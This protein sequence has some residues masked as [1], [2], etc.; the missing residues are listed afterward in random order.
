MS[1]PGVFINPSGQDPMDFDNDTATE[2]IGD[3]I[4]TIRSAKGLSQAELG[5]KIGLNAD[6]VQKYENGARKPKP[7]MIKKLAQALGV[8]TI[9][10]TDP[11]TETDLGFMYAF[12]SNEDFYGLEVTI[13]EKEDEKLKKLGATLIDK[14]MAIIFNSDRLNRDLRFWMEKQT[15]FK[16]NIEL[17]TTEE[18]KDT[19]K[20]EYKN[21]KWNYPVPLAEET[22]LEL[23]KKWLKEKI[24]Q[25]TAELDTLSNSDS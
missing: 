8:E 24:E 6:R 12:F 9:A 3:R 17:A 13:I 23:R 19:I 15:E 21:W 5:T 20:N 1:I 14:K 18:E 11:N 16:K 7:E 2:R 25:L 10:L 22:Y 4:R